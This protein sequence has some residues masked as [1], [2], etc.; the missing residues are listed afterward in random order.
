MRVLLICVIIAGQIL[1]GMTLD[2]KIQ[3]ARRAADKASGVEPDLNSGAEPGG[4][5]SPQTSGVF[6]NIGAEASGGARDGAAGAPA[7]SSSWALEAL[8]TAKESSCRSRCPTPWTFP[9]RSAGG[10]SSRG[11]SMVGFSSVT[12]QH[13]ARTSRYGFTSLRSSVMASVFSMP[14]CR[15]KYCWRFKLDKSTRSKSTRS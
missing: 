4:S 9:T 3:M 1:C 14:R 11:R 13:T 8:R 12:R 15:R 10:R 6:A 2:E 5:I 7:R